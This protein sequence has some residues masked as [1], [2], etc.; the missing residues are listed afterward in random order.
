MGWWLRSNG[1]I[2]I[3]EYEKFLK[4]LLTLYNPRQANI[5]FLFQ[6]HRKQNDNKISLNEYAPIIS[7]DINFNVDG[8]ESN[9]I[10]RVSRQVEIIQI[11]FS[12]SDI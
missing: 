8:S 9:G 12:H 1:V 7:R 10:F 4:R 2:E 5:K 6:S 11:S 3:V